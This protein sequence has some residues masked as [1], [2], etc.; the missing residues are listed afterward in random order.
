MKRIL[1]LIAAISLI[2]T[3]CTNND[4]PV[5]NQE[6]VVTFGV[7]MPE[8]T[9]TR[10]YYEG[11]GQTPEGLKMTWEAGDVLKLNFVYNETNYAADATIVDSSINGSKASFTTTIP[12]EIPE[13][14]TFT[15]YAV[16]KHGKGSFNE[17][18]YYEAID[19][20]INVTLDVEGKTISP[21]VYAVVKD[22][23]EVPSFALKHAGWVL[24]MTFVNESKED[25]VLS[26]IS[27]CQDRKQWI[28]SGNN[29]SKPWTFN[30]L[31]GKGTDYQTDGHSGVGQYIQFQ[32]IADIYEKVTISS[33]ITVYQWVCSDEDPGS[34]L[35]ISAYIGGWV[36]A[37]GVPEATVKPG[38]VYH[39]TVSWNGE[40]LTYMK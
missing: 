34:N 19:D 15:L 11:N 40:E 27:L 39:M 22:V 9:Q 10:A 4:S 17:N 3:G 30:P 8:P 26:S 18:G 13:G 7:S 25:A 14:A 1:F 29:P 12:S 20:Y 38:N 23:K 6:R 31:T 35:H 5:V 24:A 36:T 2:V 33:S 37:W 16:F 21:L 32:Q 28:Y